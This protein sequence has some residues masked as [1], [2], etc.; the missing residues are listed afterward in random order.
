MPTCICKRSSVFIWLVWIGL[1]TS[2]CRSPTTESPI[3]T[4]TVR[5]L[6]QSITFF[7]LADWGVGGLFH[8][9]AVA[10]QL[11][12]FA[13]S[14]SPS[15]LVF[16][17]DNFYTDGVQSISDPKW[18]LNFERVYTGSYLPQ[19]FAMALGNHDYQGN[20]QAQLD[21]GL[22]HPRW[23][24]P[25]RYYT[26]VFANNGVTVRLVILDTNPFLTIYRQNPA[27][28]PD[29]LQNTDRQ[30]RWADSVLTHS[31]ETC[32]IVVGHH[33]VYSAG[34]DH[35]DQPEL[36]DRLLPLLQK[37][38]APVY[39]SGHSHTLQHLPVGL[40]DF[41][42]SGG[43][44]APLGSIADS[45]RCAFGRASGGFA[46]VSVNADS[47]RLSFVNS[48]GQVLYQYGKRLIQ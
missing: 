27:T 45:T 26:K 21:Y 24:L 10:D 40:T 38:K 15:F 3:P 19:A 31:K 25:D 33:P 39:L 8:Q 48:S 43:G 30:L 4:P 13:G 32:T 28:Y 36:I 44:G 14:L 34:A 7:A 11:N 12:Q 47:L 1:V 20:V 42:I 41:I 37:H 9:Q 5:V 29:I 46:V 2:T 17:G 35:G 18:Q 22:K 6:P 23:Q 16:A